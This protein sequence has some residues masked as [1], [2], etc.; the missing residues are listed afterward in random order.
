MTDDTEDGATAEPPFT[1]EALSEKKRGQMS[2][3]DQ[4][5]YAIYNDNFRV[6]AIV[7]ETTFS[8][9]WT[10]DIIE[11]MVDE[12]D[13]VEGTDQTGLFYDLADRPTSDDGLGAEQREQIHAEARSKYTTETM[14]GDEQDITSTMNESG[15]AVDEADVDAEDTTVGESESESESEINATD[16][17]ADT[18]HAETA[19]QPTSGSGDGAVTGPQADPSDIKEAKS[20]N[21]GSLP[22]NR[23]Y[24]WNDHRLD[25]ERVNNYVEADD[26]KSDIIREIE[27]RRV[28]KKKPHFRIVGPTGCGK[29]SLAE[30]I[31][32]GMNAPYFEIQCHEGLRP[33]NLLGMPTYVGDETWWVDGPLTKAILASQ[34]RPVVV[35]FDEVNRTTSRTL[36]VI[37]SALDH[38]GSVKLNARGG[39]RIEGNPENL[40][41][42][43]T[44]NE[45]DMYTGTNNI[46][47]AQLRRL[48]NT[49]YTDYIGMYDVSEEA[50]LIADRTPLNKDVATE[51]VECANSIREKANERDSSLGIGVPTSVI[52]DWARTAWSYRGNA[53]AD[54]GP[55]V[56]AGHR[57]VI[58]LLY[59]GDDQTVDVVETTIESHLRGMEIDEED[60]DSDTDEEESETE[61]IDIGEDTWLMC[62]D[63][64]WYDESEDAD[65]EI[66]TMMC[67]PNCDSTL[68]P[69]EAV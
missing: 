28:T 16:A 2:L 21:N 56:K 59:S 69:K 37:M 23:D 50:E 49:F 4:I 47:V 58:N 11:D 9:S 48:G 14:I 53:D 32:D 10:T 18:V 7:E 8:S 52:I 27:D 13:L 34:D 5:R 40:I 62:E 39:E 67:C 33:N 35:A 38:R 19:T 44:M 60:A 29:T 12:G 20:E 6:D 3:P 66:I 22:V 24:D 42:F 57:A 46:D 1:T 63:C 36:G 51:L 17:D 68:K 30:N 61:T 43:S 26:E 54:G 55:L 41:V 45:G 25:S 15:I 64:G 65:D 31:A